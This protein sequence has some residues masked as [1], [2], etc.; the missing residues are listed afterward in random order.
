MKKSKLLVALLAAVALLAS[1]AACSLTQVEAI[2][3]TNAPEAVYSLD[4]PVEAKQFS[5]TITY[6]NG[7][8]RTVSLTDSILSVSGLNNGKLDTSSLGQKTIVVS[9]RGVTISVYYNVV[10]EGGGGIITPSKTLTG[11]NGTTENAGT[12]SNPYAIATKEDLAA[13]KSGKKTTYYQLTA[14]INLAGYEWVPLADKEGTVSTV[15][16]ENIVLDGNGQTI[17]GL[18]ITTANNT[19][20]LSLLTSGKD[21]FYGLFAGL[22]NAEVKNLTFESPY[23]NISSAEAPDHCK[24]VAA[25]TGVVAGDL[26]VDNVHVNGGYLRSNGVMAGIVG[27]LYAASEADDATKGEYKV[28]ISNCKV[29][30]VYFEAYNPITTADKDGEGDKIGGIVGHIERTSL[31]EG[32]NAVTIS[33]CVVSSCNI[34]GTRD[35]GGL[36]GW[37]TSVILNGNKVENCTISASIPGGMDNNKG[38]RNIGGLVGTMSGELRI[39]TEEGVTTKIVNTFPIKN[40]TYEGSCTGTYIGGI[41][42]SSYVSGWKIVKGTESLNLP[43]FTGSGISFDNF[44]N[45]QL[46]TMS[47]INA[48]LAGGEL[49]TLTKPVGASAATPAE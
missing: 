47:A 37:T 14:D 3:F 7:N 4:E 18:T 42:K 28:D 5:L 12:D 41:R 46:E 34:Y 20:G 36:I 8:T 13:I 29:T 38:L 1:L 24:D 23:I 19:P 39:D 31:E 30:G 26:T 21:R 40:D 32:K 17:K 44:V 2:S 33:G 15:V 48:W 10:G 35:L 9:Y 22:A 45:W 43:A 25:L 6:D 16:I 27:R 49:P 11:V